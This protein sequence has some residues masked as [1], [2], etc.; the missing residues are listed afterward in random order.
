VA[1][2]HLPGKRRGAGQEAGGQGLPTQ[3]PT[4]PAHLRSAPLYLLP[5]TC[6]L[7]TAHLCTYTCTPHCT[8]QATLCTACTGGLAPAHR[9]FFIEHTS[10]QSLCL[11][12]PG[13]PG[14]HSPHLL[15]PSHL[16]EAEYSPGGQGRGLCLHTSCPLHLTSLCTSC[17]LHLP[18]G[19]TPAHCLCTHAAPSGALLHTAA[20]L[21]CHTAHLPS[22]PQVMKEE[23]EA[24]PLPPPSPLHTCHTPAHPLTTGPHYTLSPMKVEG[25][26]LPHTACHLL[27][28]SYS[29][30]ERKSRSGV[31]KSAPAPTCPHT[32]TAPAALCTSAPTPHHWEGILH[33]PWGGPGRRKGTPL[34]D[35]EGRPALSTEVQVGDC[36]LG[37]WE[38]HLMSGSHLLLPGI[39]ERQAC[40][41]LCISSHLPHCHT[42]GQEEQGKEPL[43]SAS[44]HL[45]FSPLLYL[46][47]PLA[48]EE[49]LTSI[50]S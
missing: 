14:D 21:R 42:S 47:P 9:A 37:K 2:K 12:S 50:A 18:P 22:L 38:G 48:Q 19:D 23:G 13:E 6:P 16:L 30:T 31:A 46:A 43:A 33:L 4:S 28:T 29:G 5:S 3:E 8:P 39:G 45:L 32:L 7:H 26:F 20:L 35:Q 11:S 34:S 10:L 36:T 27:P 41:P 1:R 44:P 25:E 40:P 15:P 17:T 49:D 24:T